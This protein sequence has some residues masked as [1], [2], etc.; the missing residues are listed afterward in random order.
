MKK[1]LEKSIDFTKIDWNSLDN[2]RLQ[3]YFKEAVEAN[4]SVLNNINNINNKAYQFLA[5]ACT[6][7]AAL[8][9]FLFSVWGKS[10]KEAI[11][12]TALCGCIGLGLIMATLLVA[13]WPRTVYPGR[14]MPDSIFSGSLYKAPMTK[15]LAD[16]IASYHHYICSNRKVEKFRSFFLTAGMCGFFLVPLVAVVLLLFVF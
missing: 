15:L 7:T 4:D 3:F 12:S 16:G 10:G 6:I 9:G 13:V 14:A 2:E 11:A 1:K 8:A 5:I